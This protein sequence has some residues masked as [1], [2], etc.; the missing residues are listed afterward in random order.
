[1]TEQ[2]KKD[3]KDSHAQPAKKTGAIELDA[4]GKSLSEALR[5]SFIVL[6]V[7]MIVLVILFFASGFKTIGPDEQALVLRFGKIRGEREER[8]LGPGLVGPLPWLHWVLPYPIDEVVKIPV[9]KK[10]NLVINTF[11]YEE[12][13][14]AKERFE[15]TLNPKRDGY[16]TTRSEEQT[17][18][19][20]DSA[21]SDYNILHCKWQLTYQV[22]DPEFKNPE[23][24]FKNAYVEDVK[25]GQI[26]LDV[27]KESITPLLKSLFEDAVVTAM[28][29][30]TIDEAMFEKV[31]HVTEHVKKL[32]QEKLD[33]IE[34]GITVESVQLTDITWPRQVNAAF[35][36]LISA[37]QDSQK[38]IDEARTYATQ[39]L[40][41]AAGPVA[42]ELLD[43]IENENTESEKKEQLWS[44]LAGAGQEKIAEARAYRTK[45]VETARADA[46]YLQQILPEYRKRPQLVL[47]KIYQDAIEEVLNN[48]DE[49]IIIQP[50]ESIKGNEIW[51]QLNRDPAIKPKTHK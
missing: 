4:A 9:E 21:G 10:V 40:N 33:K 8:V 32:L 49:K 13:P 41:E 46:E 47:Q 25:P 30:Y 48:V 42:E 35:E 37:S 16:C 12:R 15:R 11:W 24:F 19:I 38:T 39:T 3:N 44:Q 45:V 51:I 34:S 17:E 14:Q 1:M 2:N 5:W 31:G 36:A 7:I 26:Y 6:K 20:G 23:R 28:V 50:T 29:N 18:T 22:K 43:A 27:M